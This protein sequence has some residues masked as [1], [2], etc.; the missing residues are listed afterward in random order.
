MYSMED[1]PEVSQG[2][3]FFGCLQT[4]IEERTA[5]RRCVA[6]VRRTWITRAPISA[7]IFRNECSR[8]DQLGPISA[9]AFVGT[10]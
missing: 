2:L 3:I 7:I 1:C 9:C 4:R 6:V 8:E 5:R 10:L